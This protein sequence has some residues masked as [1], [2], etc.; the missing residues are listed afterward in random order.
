VWF[1]SQ[2]VL[3]RCFYGSITTQTE[4]ASV[5]R[6]KLMSN[7]TQ[8]MDETREM[9]SNGCVS[10]SIGVHMVNIGLSRRNI[11]GNEDLSSQMNEKICV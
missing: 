9:S 8:S 4:Y 7:H 10:Y 3:A 6:T 2:F 11:L 1:V 5:R